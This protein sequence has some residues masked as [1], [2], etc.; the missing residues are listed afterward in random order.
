MV[1]RLRIADVDTSK[2][3]TERKDSPVVDARKSIGDAICE[4]LSGIYA[5]RSPQ[6]ETYVAEESISREQLA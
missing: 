5:G 2:P 1:K 3:R 6:I 4:I